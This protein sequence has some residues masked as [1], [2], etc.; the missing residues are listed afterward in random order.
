M[1]IVQQDGVNTFAVEKKTETL[2]QQ[3]SRNYEVSTNYS[4]K[5]HDRSGYCL[6]N[7]HIITLSTHRQR[8]ILIYFAAVAQNRARTEKN[9]K[10]C[11]N[12]M[13]AH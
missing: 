11:N 3:C 10:K 6:H 8:H 13:Y 4:S 2:S 1:V 9:N 5:P 7:V 12:K